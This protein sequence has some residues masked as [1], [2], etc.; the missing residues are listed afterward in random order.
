MTWTVADDDNKIHVRAII[1]RETE[2]EELRN[3]IAALEKRVDKK[4]PPDGQQ[5]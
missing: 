5:P 3:L 4:E 1:D 2:Q